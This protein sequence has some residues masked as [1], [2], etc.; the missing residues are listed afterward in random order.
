MPIYRRNH[1]VPEWYQSRF[2][3]QEIKEKKFYYLD[4]AP[5]HIISNGKKY[6]RKALLRWGT[7]NCFYKDDLYTTKLYGLESTEI[8]Q[9][10][11]GPV[12]S[13]GMSAVNHFSNFEYTK[14]N[15]DA[16]Q[17][18]LPYLSIQKLRTPKG[19]IWLSKIIKSNDK[20]LILHAMQK[21]QRISCALWS[22]C[23]WSIADA[24]QAQTKFIL[25]DHP[26]TVYNPNC[27]PLSEKCGPYNDPDI[28]FS[29]THTLFPLNLNKVLILT[30]LSWV[31]DP[32]S[33]PLRPRPNPSPFRDT[34]FNFTH[35]Q[36]GRLL[37]ELE[38]NEINF[39]IKSRALRYIAAAKEEWLYP[40]K[41]LKTMYWDKLGAGYLLMPDPRQ[42]DFTTEIVAG[43]KSGPAEAF[44]EYGRRPWQKNYKEKNHQDREW[45]S[46]HAFRGQFARIFGPKY[47][48]RVY[49]DIRSN[50]EEDSSGYYASLLKDEMTYKTKLKKIK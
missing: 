4:L 43:F 35:I 34:M 39:I 7:K 38:V 19:L 17:A 45:V 15:S 48:G 9:E 23:V 20:N 22:E 42:V 49:D 33:N 5:E 37:N 30:N 10:F 36:T 21:I 32:Y 13:E 41:K 28:S 6:K 29:G 18:L 46:F 12:D 14:A 31:R 11:F 24:S 3:P 40:E 1:Y 27:F 47:R 26:V 2:I 50:K 8:E 25:S 44:D 16:F